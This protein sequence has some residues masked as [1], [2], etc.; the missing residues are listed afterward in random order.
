MRRVIL[1]ALLTLVIGGCQILNQQPTVVDSQANQ[2]NQ[3]D[4]QV[5][6]AIIIEGIKVDLTQ[7][8]YAVTSDRLAHDPK[9]PGIIQVKLSPTT[10]GDLFTA[11]QFQVTDECLIL[12]NRG[13]YCNQD[14]NQL[15]TFINGNKVTNIGSRQMNSGDQL[16]ITYGD[17]TGVEIQRQINQV[18]QVIE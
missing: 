18:P 15:K 11:T 10:W 9:F 7:S 6:F 1:T 17:E 16:L 4:Y 12:N 13:Q 14:D 3:V 5:S 8:K 2:L